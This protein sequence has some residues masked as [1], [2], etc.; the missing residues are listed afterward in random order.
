MRKIWF[1]MVAAVLGLFA[2]QAFAFDS[3]A[4]ACEGCRP[5]IDKKDRTVQ[6]TGTLLK[7]RLE[8][9]GTKY[10]LFFNDKKMQ[11]RA[12]QLEG[13]TVRVTGT[14]LDFDILHAKMSP[15][16]GSFEPTIEVQSIELAEKG[17]ANITVNGKLTRPIIFRPNFPRPHPMPFH[18]EKD[19]L[20]GLPPKLP[21]PILPHFSEPEWYIDAAGQSYGLH[22]DNPNLGLLLR[23]VALE[24]K[25]VQIYGRLEM[26]RVWDDLNY[27]LLETEEINK[28]RGPLPRMQQVLVVTHVAGV[29]EDGFKEMV[30]LNVRGTVK[31]KLEFRGCVVD[32]V[33]QI[34][35]G[36]QTFTLRVE[37]ENHRKYLLEREGMDVVLGGTLEGS[38]LKVSYVRDPVMK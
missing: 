14:R 27:A 3:S 17:S 21:V 5:P 36:D 26:R 11:E 30:N 38:V 9:N 6:L 4:N 29:K 34:T 33:Y 8:V 1:F 28:I 12:K 23:L 7:G 10:T 32:I 2:V 15:G 20:I 24:G 22:F 31:T 37:N 16:C 18:W 25:K 35:T 19:P 13:R